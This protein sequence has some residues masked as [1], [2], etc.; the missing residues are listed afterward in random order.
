MET[1]MRKIVLYNKI[2]PDTF[3]TV[4]D[5]FLRENGKVEEL[6][7]L[8]Y[9]PPRKY[10]ME[11]Q[12]KIDKVNGFLNDRGYD[13]LTDQEIE[14]MIDP[15]KELK[16]V[17][18]DDLQKLSGFEVETSIKYYDDIH[19]HPHIDVKPKSIDQV[20]LDR[21]EKLKNQLTEIDQLISANKVDFIDSNIDFTTIRQNLLDDIA[22]HESYINRRKFSVEWNEVLQQLN[23]IQNGQV[24]DTV[25]SPTSVSKFTGHIE[26]DNFSKI[27]YINSYLSQNS[28][29]LLTSEEIEWILY[30]E[31]ENKR[32][33]EQFYEDPKYLQRMA[34]FEVLKEVRPTNV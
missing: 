32:L 34:G 30:D 20:Y 27:M 11:V 16:N 1:N 31:A 15:F 7:V 10:S 8:N 9:G 22:R 23:I 4:T 26:I 28:L 18:I 21:F 19:E 29:D 5:V 6:G 3:E 17:T 33:Q 13:Q 25:P 24:V 2:N 14:Y 12:L